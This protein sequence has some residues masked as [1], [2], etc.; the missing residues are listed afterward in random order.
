M[1]KQAA[2]AARRVLIYVYLL[3]LMTSAHRSDVWQHGGMVTASAIGGE[4]IISGSMRGSMAIRRGGSVSGAKWREESNHRHCWYRSL[5]Q[6]CR[7]KSEAA[8]IVKIG[9]GGK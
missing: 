6:H 2:V 5:Y 9:G 1:K 8:G 4:N 7:R 3:C